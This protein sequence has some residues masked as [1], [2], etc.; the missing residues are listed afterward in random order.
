MPWDTNGTNG[1]LYAG[2]EAAFTD[3]DLPIGTGYAGVF[4]GKSYDERYTVDSPIFNDKFID[5][6]AMMKDW[7]DNGDSREDVLN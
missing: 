5:F 2:F 3:I 7:A 1:T 6:A 4:T